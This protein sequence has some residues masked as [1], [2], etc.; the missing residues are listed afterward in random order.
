MTS[1]ERTVLRRLELRPKAIRERPHL[2]GFTISRMHSSWAIMNA[3]KLT[4]LILVSPRR[5]Q[6]SE[7]LQAGREIPTHFGPLIQVLAA[8]PLHEDL[9]LDS[10]SHAQVSIYEPGGGVTTHV[11]HK[12][13]SEP[14]AIAFFVWETVISF[15][16][17]SGSHYELDLKPCSVLVLSKDARTKVTHGIEP[18][19]SEIREVFASA[20]LCALSSPRLCLHDNARPRPQP[21]AHGLRRGEV[22]HPDALWSFRLCGLFTFATQNPGFL[23]CPQ[24][25]NLE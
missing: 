4:N 13:Y 15:T 20:L 9:R 21:A 5:R 6:A 8:L 10:W 3:S 22:R 17:P 1:T 2:M 25:T 19:A 24:K 14:I 7:S 12:S 11:D 23:P 18:R 16:E